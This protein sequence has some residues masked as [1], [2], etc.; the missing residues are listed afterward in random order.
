MTAQHNH[1]P[2][3]C[4]SYS[5]QPGPDDICPGCIEHGVLAS[6]PGITCPQC[7]QPAGHDHAA[8]CTLAPGRVW[9]G[10]I[11]ARG[12]VEGGGGGYG[13]VPAARPEIGAEDDFVGQAL[14]AVDSDSAGSWPTVAGYL[15]DEVRRLDPRRQQQP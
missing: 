3:C 1:P 2:R 11:P 4:C 5:N 15:A 12:M 7:H 14:A 8:D 6:R 9:D 13:L 10:T